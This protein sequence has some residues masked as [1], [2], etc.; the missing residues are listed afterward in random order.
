MLTRRDILKTGAAMLATGAVTLAA[1]N[2][3]AA[4]KSAA[5]T[6]PPIPVPAG[7]SY[8]PCV[9]PNGSTLPWKMD[10]GVKVFH[11]I[12]EPVK[13]EF[14]PGMVVNCW[15]YNGQTPGPTIEA[16]EGDRLRIYVTNRLG[17][18]TSVHWHGLFVPNGM[19]G[20]AGLTQKHIPPGKTYVYEFALRQNGSFMYHPHSDEMLQMALGMMGW[21]IVHPKDP[22]MHRV[23]R[24]FLLMLHNWDVEPGAFTPQPAT[25]TE[26]NMWTM[27]SRIFPGT[28]P[29]VVRRGDRV[30][31]RVANL[32]MH[33][34][35]MHI[36]GYSML[37]TGTDGGWLEPSARWSETTALIPVGAIRA[38]EFVAGE[39]G[40]WAFHCHKSH[41]TM[42][43]MGHTVPNMVGVDQSGVSDKISDLLPD[44][45]AMGSKGMGDM[46]MMQEMGMPLP[47]NTL[48]MMTGTGPFGPVE[49]GGMFTVIKV[50]DGIAPGDYADPGWYKHP[51]GTVAWEASEEEM[52]RLFG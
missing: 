15:G 25:M 17:E 18:P 4:E 38:L 48:P 22:G 41:H 13:R 21:F 14:A 16:V 40:D 26:F 24:D 33:E 50:R 3:T 23:D 47:E 49:M 20:V 34:H 36:H 43:A 1:R 28:D 19:D 45:M 51:P 8:T 39:P 5:A 11:L 9:T 42:N 52:K 6:R 35:P 44:Y 37:V 12:A 31:I 27:N 7:Q 10:N 46:A 29:L 2:A 30:R 32:S